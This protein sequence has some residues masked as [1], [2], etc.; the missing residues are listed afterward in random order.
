MAHGTLSLPIETE[1]CRLREFSRDDL[2]AMHAYAARED[3]TRFLMWGPN[4][5][6]ASEKQLSTF[7]EAAV[8]TPR[9]VYELALV[10]RSGGQLIGA[11]CL[12]LDADRR[13]A[14]LGFV[15]HPDFWGRGLVTE[16]AAAL[17]QSGFSTL[18]LARIWATCDTRN[19]ASVS[20]LEKVG[21]VREETV[22]G[23]RETPDGLV[24]EHRYALD[25]IELT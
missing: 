12:Y 7:L 25:A 21:M 11:L 20:V 1:R 3:V 4:D 10:P 15:L 6:P 9:L 19:V 14:E 22:R 16:A 24:D 18:N 8:E 2:A 5:L 23:A 17:L 13:T